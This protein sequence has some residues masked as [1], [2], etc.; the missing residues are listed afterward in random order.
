MRM[1]DGAKFRD[2]EQT[3]IIIGSSSVY[4]VR[5]SVASD[6][7]QSFLKYG[8]VRKPR[9]YYKRKFDSAEKQAV[10]AAL[11]DYIRV[12]NILY[13]DEIQEKLRL[14]FGRKYSKSTVCRWLGKLGYSSKVLTRIAIQR[15][16]H[17][18]LRFLL[19]VRQ[20]PVENLVFIDEV[21]KNDATCRRNR[22]WALRGK[23]ARIRAAFDKGTK[24]SVLAA[25]N[26]DGFILDACHSIPTRG[27]DA[28][29]VREW[30]E[31]FLLPHLTNKSVV[32]ADNASIHHAINLE[33]LVARKGASVLWLP[34]YRYVFGEVYSVF[35]RLIGA[36]YTYSCDLNPIEEGF[37]DYKSYLRRHQDAALASD[38]ES[39]TRAALGN[40]STK[41]H[42]HF[43]H[44]HL[45]VAGMVE[46]LARQ[47]ADLMS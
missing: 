16:E 44:C 45:D 34:P 26:V 22:G 46:R 3:P 14:D 38:H 41:M 35:F 17:E 11:H 43:T 28:S 25:C 4:H 42:K 18:R 5:R 8:D 37:H 15:D 2:I 39:M 24:Y 9:R 31:I 27:V 19:A 20:I 30:V 13:L 7:V 40:V 47:H 6:A 21:H 23:R 12:K 1:Y 29:T 10:H 32:V 36:L 33:A